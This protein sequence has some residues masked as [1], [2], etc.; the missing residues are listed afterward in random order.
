MRREKADDNDSAD[1][2]E[3]EE[4]GRAL[5]RLGSEA[6]ADKDGGWRRW[7]LEISGSWTKAQVSSPVQ[8]TYQYGEPAV[9]RYWYC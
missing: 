7:R 9:V 2:E 1:G 6:A 4:E 5:S 8:A 3:E